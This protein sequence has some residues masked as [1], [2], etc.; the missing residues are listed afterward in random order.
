M[1]TVTTLSMMRVNKRN[2]VYSRPAIS[3]KNRPTSRF[4]PTPWWRTDVTGFCYGA[5]FGAIDR[6]GTLHGTVTYA[7]NPVPHAPVYLYLMPQGMLLRSLW[8]DASGNYT[9]KG[10]NHAYDTYLVVARYPSENALVFDTVVP[11]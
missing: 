6:S 5:G 10:L 9:F 1:A 11:A 8:S 2:S 7:T 4:D 3:S